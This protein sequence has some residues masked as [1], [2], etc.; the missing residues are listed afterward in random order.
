MVATVPNCHYAVSPLAHLEMFI[1][2]LVL[3]VSL[4]R[5]SAGFTSTEVN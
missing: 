1:N 4:P 3:R 5:F 2:H